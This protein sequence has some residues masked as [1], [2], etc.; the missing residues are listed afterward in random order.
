MAVAKEQIQQ[1]MIIQRGTEMYIT[2]WEALP[3]ESCLHN[4]ND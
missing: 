3:A 4:Y 1:I 2:T